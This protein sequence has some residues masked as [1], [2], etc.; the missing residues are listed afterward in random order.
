VLEQRR[1][2]EADESRVRQGEAH[3]ARELP[4]LC[5]VRC[6]AAYWLLYTIAS[7]ALSFSGIFRC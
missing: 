3:V 4:C 7:T 6:L 1:A 2:R 5:A